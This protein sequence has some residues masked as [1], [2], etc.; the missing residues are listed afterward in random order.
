MLLRTTLSPIDHQF[1]RSDHE[2][3]G[4]L[5][6]RRKDSWS[7]NLFLDLFWKSVSCHYGYTVLWNHNWWYVKTSGSHSHLNCLL[8][9][10]ISTFRG[11][12]LL[13]NFSEKDLSYSDDHEGGIWTRDHEI[14][15]YPE[16]VFSGLE[17]IEV[18]VFDR[19]S[20]KSV[21]YIFFCNNSG[22]FIGQNK[23]TYSLVFH[24]NQ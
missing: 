20:S 9:E 24:L 2:V 3:L 6:Q 10:R 4:P 22:T 16:H 15:K 7:W 5:C 13:A 19:I 11:Y 18:A 21:Q 8:I 14:H 1:L 12:A 23:R 17:A